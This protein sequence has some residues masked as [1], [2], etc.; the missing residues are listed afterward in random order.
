[1][2]HLFHFLF[3]QWQDLEQSS[4]H[5]S[6]SIP[7]KAQLL[8]GSGNNRSSFLALRTHRQAA[9]PC[10]LSATLAHPPVPISPSVSLLLQTELTPLN[11]LQR[12][13]WPSA[14]NLPET[15]GFGRGKCMP[16]ALPVRPIQTLPL[17]WTLRGVL[18][19]A[20]SWV[21]SE[22][23][24]FTSLLDVQGPPKLI[25]RAGIHRLGLSAA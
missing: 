20:L 10:Q 16:S 2:R 1:M 6:L 22:N 24:L 14:G 3:T 4:Y 21:L 11:L 19:L 25:F 23:L 8:S 18:T 13:A 5:V 12:V 9:I 7:T 17:S 15:T